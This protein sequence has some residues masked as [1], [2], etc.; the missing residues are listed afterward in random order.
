MNNPMTNK[1]ERSIE[2]I[3]YEGPVLKLIESGSEVIA[4]D[5]WDKPIARLNRVSLLS[6]LRG[7]ISFYDS[8]GKEWHYP[9]QHEESRTDINK[10][11]E[12]FQKIN[13]NPC[14]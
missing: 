1:K 9:S 2:L 6:Y 3:N 12:F 5:Q 4:V 10:L 8:K 7:E 11:M 13:D 14:H